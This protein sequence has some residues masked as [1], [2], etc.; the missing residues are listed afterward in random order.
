MASIGSQSGPRL[1]LVM[2]YR[3]TDGLAIQPCRLHYGTRSVGKTAYAWPGRYDLWSAHPD[4]RHAKSR[5]S[6]SG[7]GAAASKARSPLILSFSTSYPRP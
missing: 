2:L 1:I 4:C 6:V 3:R 7:W 5:S